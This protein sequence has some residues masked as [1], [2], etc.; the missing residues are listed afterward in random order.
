MLVLM[1]SQLNG[2]F[3]HPAFQ[4]WISPVGLLEG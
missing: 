3:Y 1:A 4:Q 2:L